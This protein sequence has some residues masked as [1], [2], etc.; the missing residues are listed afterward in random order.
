[1]AGGAVIEITGSVAAEAIEV[2]RRNARTASFMMAIEEGA[3]I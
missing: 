2:K 3:K 1:M